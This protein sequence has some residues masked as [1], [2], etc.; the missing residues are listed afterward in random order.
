M[1]RCGVERGKRCPCQ[2]P[3][4]SLAPPP[5]PAGTCC[6]TQPAAP[7]TSSTKARARG[8]ATAEASPPGLRRG[9][10]ARTRGAVAR[11]SRVHRPHGRRS[12]D[13]L[14]LFAVFERRASDPRND[15]GI[16][17]SDFPG[18]WA[19]RRRRSL[20]RRCL[21]EGGHGRSM[22]RIIKLTLLDFRLPGHL[23]A[24]RLARGES[25]TP[26]A[27]PKAARQREV[28]L[29]SGAPRMH[30]RPWH[31]PG[32][33]RRCGATPAANSGKSRCPPELTQSVPRP[34]LRAPPFG[35]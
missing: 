30:R 25:C 4:S 22:L 32:D 29:G 1:H 24:L 7:V 20:A 17:M 27:V 33:L 12:A 15:A 16:C 23:A 13:D 34:H 31:R 3:A 28:A 8:F 10:R 35:R 5:S 6:S 14:F 19:E 2:K 11:G 26:L 18:Q 21:E 9:A